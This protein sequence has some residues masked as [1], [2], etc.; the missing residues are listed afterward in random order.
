SPWAQT[1]DRL[2]RTESARLLCLDVVGGGPTTPVLL[3]GTMSGLAQIVWP[4]PPVPWR[5]GPA[6]VRSLAATHD[7]LG[8]AIVFAVGGDDRVWC[9]TPDGWL[10]SEIRTLGEANAVRGADGLVSCHLAAADGVHSLTVDASGELRKGFTPHVWPRGRH[11]IVGVHHAPGSGRALL[12]NGESGLSLLIDEDGGL[13][14]LPVTAGPVGAA[15]VAQN[16]FGLIEVMA[17]EP[18]GRTVHRWELMAGELDQLDPLDAGGPVTSLA[19]VSHRTG[20][21]AAFGGP[22]GVH[23][24]QEGPDRTGSWLEQTAGVCTRVVIKPTASWPLQLAALVDG[25]PLSWTETDPGR[26]TARRLS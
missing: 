22:H 26:W 15:A 10:R 19:F 24:Y 12:V 5:P 20:L 4:D 21:T 3:T 11:D 1:L 13:A 25:A 18:G 9:R 8:R 2:V 23:L 14:V 17:A 7:G 6:P 16:M